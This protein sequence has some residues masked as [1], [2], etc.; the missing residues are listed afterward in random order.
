MKIDNSPFKR[1]CLS[2]KGK[3]YIFDYRTGKYTKTV[4]VACDKNGELH[5]DSHEDGYGEFHYVQHIITT[6]IFRG[7]SKTP[8]FTTTDIRNT[9]IRYDNDIILDFNRSVLTL[10]EVLGLMSF[11]KRLRSVDYLPITCTCCK[12]GYDVGK[13]S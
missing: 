10:N 9:G 11:I 7:S 6:E 1:V 4:C 2:C 8:L 5:F 12:T 13:T 3:K